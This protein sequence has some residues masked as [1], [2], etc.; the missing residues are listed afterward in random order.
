MARCSGCGKEAGAGL[1]FCTSCGQPVIE[2]AGPK[3][4]KCGRVQTKPTKF[5][6]G[7]GTALEAVGAAPGARPPLPPPPPAGMPPGP[8]MPPAPPAAKP[9]LPPP[10]PAGMPPGPFAGPGAMP[11]P[12]PAVR[13]PLAAMPQPVMAP[14]PVARKGGG[15]GLVAALL[16]GVAVLGAGGYFGYKKF[17]AKGAPAGQASQPAAGTTPGQPS[18]GAGLPAPLGTSAAP[19]PAPPA[20]ASPGDTTPA[21]PPAMGSTGKAEAQHSARQTAASVPAGGGTRAAAHAPAQRP[22]AAVSAPPPQQQQAAEWPSVAPAQAPNAQPAQQQPRAPQRTPVFR[23]EPEMPSQPA[24]AAAARY[25]GPASG[26]LIWSGPLKKDSVVTID[27]TQASA[28]TVQGSL[29]GVPV[30]VETDFK[31][32][33]F[34]EMPGPSNGW[35]K[36]GIR[37]RKNQNVVVTMRWKVI[38]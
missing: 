23:P 31:D 24:A 3:C 2:A 29:P 35:K 27:G 32:I 16:V 7:C 37:G 4:P 1:K 22:P 19:A 38:Q 33:G 20:S 17:F 13:Q 30:T 21:A 8:P 11:P 5:C 34:A 15:V 26:T 25:T 12:P 18:P 28:G 10:P 14:P 6:V 9:P 36:I